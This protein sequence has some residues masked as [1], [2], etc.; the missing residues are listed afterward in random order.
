VSHSEDLALARR[1]ASAE[2]PAFDALFERYADRVHALALRRTAEA[3]SARRLAERMLERIFADIDQYRGDV[4]LDAWVLC[5][6][7]RVLAGPR[8]TPAER[9]HALPAGAASAS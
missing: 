7:K 6:C 4:S 9:P 2:R 1:V 3:A 5:V 8:P